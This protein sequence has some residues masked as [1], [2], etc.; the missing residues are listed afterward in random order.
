MHY[1]NDSQ[2]IFDAKEQVRQIELEIEIANKEKQID[3]I[4]KE[5]S[6][7]ENKLDLLDE[8]ENRGNDFYDILSK[9]TE[10]YYNSQLKNL[11]KQRKET[12]KKSRKSKIEIPRTH[13]DP[14]KSGT[15]SQTQTV[16][17]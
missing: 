15:F 3:L 16:R 6:L 4:E 2:G 5:I 8:E 9:Q 14:R 11:E 13:R 1:E 10:D 12:D 17:Y 7:L